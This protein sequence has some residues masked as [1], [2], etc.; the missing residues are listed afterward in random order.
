MNKVKNLS[1]FFKWLFWAFFVGWPIVLA[2]IWLGPQ[3]A[4]GF[5]LVIANFLP[6]GLYENILVPLS[7]SLIWLGFLVSFIPMG[8]GM[9]MSWFFLK[10]F[11]CYEIGEI[12]TLRSNSYIK[13]I[14]VVLL[15]GVPLN[16]LYQVLITLVM[17]SKNPA[18][19]RMVALAIGASDIRDLITAGLVLLVAHIMGE[20]LK[21]REEQ[22]L[23]V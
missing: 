20:A 13:K 7:P 18:G 17:T 22:V 5:G 21:L 2:F 23:T 9:A 11:R 16:L 1:R 19:H 3:S 14:G 15:L 10:L 6:N 8:V 12:F 4:N